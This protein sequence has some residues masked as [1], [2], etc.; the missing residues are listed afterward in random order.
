MTNQTTSK[1]FMEYLFK[2]VGAA[3]EYFKAKMNAKEAEGLIINRE[4][5]EEIFTEWKKAY[6]K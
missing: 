5:V 2:L 6:E 1:E 4:I 3:E